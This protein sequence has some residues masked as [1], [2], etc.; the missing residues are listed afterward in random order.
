MPTVVC[1]QDLTNTTSHLGNPPVFQYTKPTR[2]CRDEEKAH[3]VTSYTHMIEARPDY[4]E[5]YYH[6]YMLEASVHQYKL[7]SA[8]QQSSRGIAS[9]SKHHIASYIAGPSCL[10][11]SVPSNSTT[12]HNK[13]QPSD[14]STTM[15]ISIT[16]LKNSISR[17]RALRQSPPC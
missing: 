15:H 6:H 8:P 3:A 1:R 9:S 16:I 17:A 12:K 13:T 4:D 5:A 14:P 7:M 10:N 2:P 11:T